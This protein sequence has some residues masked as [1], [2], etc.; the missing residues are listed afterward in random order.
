[1]N[2]PWEPF[3][4]PPPPVLIL[5]MHNSGTTML[6][7]ILHRSGLFLGNNAAHNESHFF[8]LFINDR[9]LLGGGDAWARLP[10]PSVEQVL[11]RRDDV[12]PLVL[13]YWRIDYLQYGYDGSGPW[14]IKDPRLC[15]LLPLYLELFPQA[16]LLLIRRDPEDLAASLAHRYKPGVG[17]KNDPEHWRRLTLAHWERVEQFSG[18]HPFFHQV[19]YERL[20]R[21]PRAVAPGIFEFVGLPYDEAAD[22]RVRATVKTDR[23]GTKHWPESRW[24][25]E[26]RIRRWK[27]LFGPLYYALTGRG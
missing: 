3:V 22:A 14:G 12:G 6:A 23:I 9:L 5:G 18:S 1:M 24:R 27:Q 11:A 15:I 26:A 25:R 10:F 21:D 17:L 16:R 13:D 7:D 4:E 8:S 20:C 19:E 2:L